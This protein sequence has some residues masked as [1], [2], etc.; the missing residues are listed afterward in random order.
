MQDNSS[1]RLGRELWRKDH[2]RSHR[3]TQSEDIGISKNDTKRRRAQRWTGF[4]LS[5]YQ[6]I[7]PSPSAFIRV[8]RVPFLTPV[9]ESWRKGAED[10]TFLPR[11]ARF[12]IA[13]SAGK[14]TQRWTSL[15][16]PLYGVPKSG[17]GRQGR[18]DARRSPNG[19]KAGK[20]KEYRS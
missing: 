15:P 5:S 1:V 8:L 20:V 14:R 10:A 3:L 6:I 16:A 11:T 12:S 13:G 19:T 18:G 7:P 2:H 4:S 17:T 9:L